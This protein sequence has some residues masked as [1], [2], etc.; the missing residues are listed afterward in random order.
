ML[1]I[2]YTKMQQDFTA[3]IIDEKGVC[4]N[5]FCG[6]SIKLRSFE[7]YELYVSDILYI[8]LSL[9]PTKPGK[10]QPSS[11]FLNKYKSLHVGLLQYSTWYGN[12]DITHGD[13]NNFTIIFKHSDKK[14]VL[15]LHIR[16]ATPYEDLDILRS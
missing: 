4:E 15:P 5:I 9:L 1:S 7:V 10:G 6:M 16:L 8:R 2:I 11:K 3:I 13:E 14:Y 12:C